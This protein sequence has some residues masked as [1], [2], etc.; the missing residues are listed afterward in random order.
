[1]KQFDI[2]GM[3]CAAC[4]ARVQKAVE[5]V[6]G[7]SFCAVNLLT[8]SMQIDGAVSERSVIAAVEAAG[9]KATLKGRAK[10]EKEKID[11]M[12][13]ARLISSAILL[14]VLMYVSMG[15]I[16]L[17][18]LPEFIAENPFLN[19]FIQMLLSAAVMV[20]NRKFFIN[21]VKGLLKGTPNMD[22]LV[23]LG[24]IASFGYSLYVLNEMRYMGYPLSA[25]PELYFESAV[26]ILV[27][28]TVGKLLE[29]RSKGKT[30]DAV[31]SL[32]ELAPETATVLRNGKEVTVDINE[33]S[34]GDIFTLRPGE[35]IPADGTIVEGESA[36]NEAA[37]T[38]ESIPVDK[39]VGDT[40]STAAIN[41]SGYLKVRAERV[42]E[43]TSLYKIIKAVT[44]SAASKA[45]IAKIAD[46]VS[47]VFVPVVIGIALITA[48]GWLIAGETVGFAVAR[49]V[50]VLVISCPCALGLATPVA[51]MVASGVGAK[52]GILYKTAEALENAGKSDIIVLDKTG[53]V[54]EG[55]PRVSDIIPSSGT[56]QTELLT[57][58]VAIEAK[59]EHPLAKAIIAEAIMKGVAIKPVEGFKAVFGNGVEGILDG[60]TIYG[61]SLKYIGERTE[62][63]STVLSAAEALS[64]KG[65]TPLAFV[66]DSRLLGIIAVADTVRVDS[67]AAVEEMR[68]QKLRVVMLTGDNE[69]TARAIAASVGI[70]EVIAGVL[71]EGKV[72]AIERLKTEGKVAFVGDGINDA[73]ALTAADTGIAIGAGTD[74]AIDSADVVLM[75]SRL[76]DATAAIRLSRKTFK[77]IKEN[78][79][80]AFFYNIIGIPLAAGLFGL[81]LSPMFGAAAMS[82]SSLFVVSNALRLNFIKLKN[83]TQKETGKMD[84]V[85]SCNVEGMMCEH[86]AARVKDALE[87]LEE[88]GEATVHLDTGIVE[89]R[90]DYP[91]DIYFMT[92]T[93]ESLGYKVV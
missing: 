53:T 85:L 4:S 26:M 63:E 71:P 55:V 58:A 69:K 32:M 20:I 50:S 68:K 34:V 12:L 25:L 33:L 5:R 13:I 43:E 11:K 9:Y 10:P 76:S 35:H 57:A 80:W 62:L 14:A 36:V 29:E 56:S 31:N 91:M 88:I 42:G 75:Y 73:P 30:T 92:K 16:I 21:G 93:I 28:I 52:N 44:D 6:D 40:V 17:L 66:L 48:F 38:G 37:L 47:G 70:T 8:N 1:M 45:P 84:K 89:A 51:I 83:K 90:L 39:G 23:S 82:I 15:H 64:E 41:L 60:K 74:I 24:S 54:T 46:R 18:P 86:C 3:S 61:G 67:V 7:V 72:E 22:T 78:L 81:Q 65:K 49:G 2:K 79:F 19:G 87:K 77:N 27:I 59:S